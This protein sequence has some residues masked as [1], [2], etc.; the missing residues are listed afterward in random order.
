MAA[1]GIPET[2]LVPLAFQDSDS[3]VKAGVLQIQRLHLLPGI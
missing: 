2:D 1:T 3:L